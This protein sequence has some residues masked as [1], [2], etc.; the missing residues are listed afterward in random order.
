MIA[1]SIDIKMAARF[2]DL[3]GTKESFS[4][5]TF[6]D[7]K[8]SPDAAA[9][10]GYKQPKLARILHGTLLKHAEE[11]AR[12]N[13]EGAG[14]FFTVNETD[15]QGRKA[16]NI[17]R[18]RALF[19]DLDGA[20][21]DPV[22]AHEIKPHI[23]VES[24]PGRFHAYWLTDDCPLDEFKSAQQKLAHQFKGDMKVCDLPRVM[25]LPGFIHQ[26]AEPF[27]TRIIFPE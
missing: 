19:V 24:S 17:I 14:V 26:K 10:K 13:K 27:M 20:P 22:L 11:L 21:L 12:L 8:V 5:Q 6:A 23:V 18:V 15:G 16:G 9:M 1:S 4:F 3:F 2:L 7:K 25:R